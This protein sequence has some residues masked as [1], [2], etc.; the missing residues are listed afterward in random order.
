MENY[1][2]RIAQAVGNIK[3]IDS[4]YWNATLSQRAEF[5]NP[6]GSMV[7]GVT[8]K[9][10]EQLLLDAVWE[11]YSHESIEEGCAGFCAPIKGRLGVIPLASLPSDTLVTLD[12]RKNTGKVS[13]TVQGVLGA[14]VD[15]IVIILG[16][17]DGVEIVFT[18]HPGEPVRPSQVQAQP[19]MHGRS[20]TVLKALDMGLET[21]KIV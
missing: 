12:D 2:D 20:V 16:I 21:V 1:H 15:F 18:F 13:A 14:E 5:G 11:S 6:A 4:D 3:R 19:G 17:E 10:L 8:P 9:E 7:L